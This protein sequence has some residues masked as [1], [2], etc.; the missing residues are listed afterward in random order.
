M[1]VEGSFDHELLKSLRNPQSIAVLTGA[2]VSAESGIPTFRDALSGYWAKFDPEELA[3]PTAFARDP[4]MVSRW[5]DER[6]CAVAKCKPN[7]GHAALASLQS[8]MARDGRVFTLITQNVD[9]LHQAAG[10]TGVIE[11][12]GSLWIWRCE[13]CGNENEELG[14]AFREYPILCTCGGKRRPGVVWFG[15]ALPADAL[16]AAQRAAG[17]CELFISVGTSSLVYPAA[18]LIDVALGGGGRLLE[19]N[20]QPTPYSSRATWS[21]RGTSAQML[22]ALIYA[23]F[24][25]SAG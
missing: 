24:G 19:V 4:A 13:D 10:S 15:E 14:P 9:R 23:A 21:L 1:S 20:P 18:G 8:W 5:Y 16:T 25:D 12:H 7:A 11:L 17:N 3:T 6:R 22:P 2:G